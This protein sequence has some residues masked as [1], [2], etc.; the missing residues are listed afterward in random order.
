MTKLKLYAVRAFGDVASRHIVAF[1]MR[2]AFLAA[3]AMISD[4]NAKAKADWESDDGGMVWSNYLGEITEC[5]EVPSI[6]VTV[7]GG[8]K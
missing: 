7:V 8:H 4:A 3:E 6:G 2:E 5:C 1:S